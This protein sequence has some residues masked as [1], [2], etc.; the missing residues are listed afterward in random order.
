M[1]QSAQR[2]LMSPFRRPSELSER[3]ERALAVLSVRA[4]GKSSSQARC[5]SASYSG[6]CSHLPSGSNG[7]RTDTAP[8]SHGAARFLDHLVDV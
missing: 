8:T 4:I 1:V 5:Q 2:Q 3:F 7:L 6:S